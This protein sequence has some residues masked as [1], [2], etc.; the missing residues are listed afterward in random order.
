MKYITKER[1]IRTRKSIKDIDKRLW[2]VCDHIWVRIPDSGRDLIKKRC[3]IC[4]LGYLPSLY[5]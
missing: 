4:G 3:E 1:N 2:E 5:K